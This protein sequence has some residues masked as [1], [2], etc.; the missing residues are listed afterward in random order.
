MLDSDRYHRGAEFLLIDSLLSFGGDDISGVM[1]GIDD[2]PQV[3]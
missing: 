3:S 2:F 1:A